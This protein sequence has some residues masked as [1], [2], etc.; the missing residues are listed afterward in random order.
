MMHQKKAELRK[1]RTVFQRQ[2]WNTKVGVPVSPLISQPNNTTTTKQMPRKQQPLPPGKFDQEKSTTLKL[3]RFFPSEMC[4][5]TSSFFS[6]T[7][8]T[9]GR[10]HIGRGEP[11]IEPRIWEGM[12]KRNFPNPA[13]LGFK[14]LYVHAWNELKW[15]MEG[16]AS[17]TGVHNCEFHSCIGLTTVPHLKYNLYLVYIP[18]F[19]QK[20]E[21]MKQSEQ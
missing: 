19:P 15:C 8:T 5:A 17:W 21:N 20:K 12:L 1:E 18:E 3:A 4:Q 14:C 2:V 6:K 11:S 13:Y 9:Y 7:S 16:T 10:G